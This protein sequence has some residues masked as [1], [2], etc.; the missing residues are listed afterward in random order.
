MKKLFF[1]FILISCYCAATAQQKYAQ[2]G[3]KLEYAIYPSGGFLNASVLID[4]FAVDTI[5]LTWRIDY[6]SG[7]RA[8]VKNS[9]ENGKLGYWNPPF[10]GEDIIIDEDKVM[11]CISRAS[12]RELK[13]SL[14]M[15]FDGQLFT[16]KEKSLFYKVNNTEVNA[17]YVESNNSATR[18]WILDDA[19]FPLILKL[20][21]NPFNVDVE[22]I[23]IHLKYL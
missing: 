10:D 18:L 20:E 21:G 8:M 13:E 1:S 16:V 2:Q 4:R 22:L 17:V 9:L 19:F 6:R 12:F 11:L 7:R 15:E 14:K 23:G 5:A 3:T